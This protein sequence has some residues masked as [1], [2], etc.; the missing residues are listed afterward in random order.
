MIDPN[1]ATPAQMA[2]YDVSYLPGQD[3]RKLPLFAGTMGQPGTALSAL[4]RQQ[5]ANQLANQGIKIDPLIDAMTFNN[6]PSVVMVNY[7]ARAGYTVFS[8]IGEPNPDEQTSPPGQSLPNLPPYNP[9]GHTGVVAVDPLPPFVAPPAPPPGTGSLIG[10]FTGANT[11]ELG[12]PGPVV[13]VYV[14]SIKGLM[15]PSG[16]SYTDPVQG[17]PTFGQTFLFYI[18]GNALMSNASASVYW[19]GPQPS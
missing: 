14:P 17:S 12:I 3:P 19:L 8:Y 9:A 4:A 16:F 13:D 15:L 1:N 18:A 10:S 6:D 7:R 2:A 5:L 11:S